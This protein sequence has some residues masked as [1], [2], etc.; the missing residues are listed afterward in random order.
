MMIFSRTETNAKNRKL[1]QTG[2]RKHHHENHLNL[3]QSNQMETRDIKVDSNSYDF[4]YTVLTDSTCI[5]AVVVLTPS[6]A[7]AALSSKMWQR[8]TRRC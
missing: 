4:S 6:A 1:K 8:E 2:K 5:A 3:N 7:T